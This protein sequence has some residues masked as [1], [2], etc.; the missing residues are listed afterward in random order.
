MRDSS[1]PLILYDGVCGLCNSLVRFVLRHDKKKIFKFA[2]LQGQSA[3]AILRRHGEN[4]EALDT[5]YVVLNS[6]ERLLSRSEAALF[7]WRELGGVWG[8]L[9]AVFGIFPAVLRNWIYRLIASNRYRV[10]GRYESCPLPDPRVRER[11]L[12]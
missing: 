12:E 1:Y 4:P 10:F 8:V 7:I 6:G 3:Q 2:A 9:A 11:F 5:M